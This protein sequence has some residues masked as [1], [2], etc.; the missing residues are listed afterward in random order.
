MGYSIS[1][2]AFKGLPLAKAALVFGLAQSGQSDEAF[3]FAY[4]GA[5]VGQNWSVVLFNDVNI[6]LVDEK[7]LANLST[8]RDM[9]VVHNI[10]AVMLQWAE[11]W[12]D[13][14]EVWSI[15]HTSADGARNLEATG[16]LPTCFEEIRRARFADQDREDAGAAA[17]DFIAD[18][19]LE[20]AECVTGFRHNTVGVEFMELVPAPGE[21]K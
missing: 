3:D 15:Q 19:P 16:N 10:D 2:V 20:V 11:Q 13:G 8:G 6:H 14:H 1:W 21:T 17:I 18:I 7:R 5:T 9:V 12:R 4:N